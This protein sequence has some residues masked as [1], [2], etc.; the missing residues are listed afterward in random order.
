MI[1]PPAFRPTSI[2]AREPAAPC[3][4]I[5]ATDT[6]PRCTPAEERVEDSGRASAVVRNVF[7]RSTATTG[8]DDGPADN[9]ST[10]KMPRRFAYLAHQHGGDERDRVGRRSARAR[11]TR[12]VFCTAIGSSG[13]WM[14]VG[15]SCRGPDP[16]RRAARGS[17]AAATI[18]NRSSRS[19]TTRNAAEDEQPS[20]AGRGASSGPP[21]RTPG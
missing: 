3:S 1:V 8:G 16:R 10:L 13:S 11:R 17:C 21:P 6:G 15:G 2:R 7:Q 19:G 12:R 5:G 9:A 20:A 4:V 18:S 14:T